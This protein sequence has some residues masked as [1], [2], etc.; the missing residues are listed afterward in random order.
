MLLQIVHGI[1][2]TD[3]TSIREYLGR[4]LQLVR[5][6]SQALLGWLLARRADQGSTFINNIHEHLFCNALLFWFDDPH[7][8]TNL[9]PQ[10]G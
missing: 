3:E 5:G 10:G 6:S 2:H 8:R 4:D 9:L 1:L 7:S